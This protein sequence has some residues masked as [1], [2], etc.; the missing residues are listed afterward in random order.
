MK[1]VSLVGILKFH[2]AEQTCAWSQQPPSRKK[3]QSRLKKNEDCFARWNFETG[4]QNMK[5]TF[6]SAENLVNGKVTYTI[7]LGLNSLLL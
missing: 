2:C 7:Y 6:V 5:E 4:L 1:I 3:N